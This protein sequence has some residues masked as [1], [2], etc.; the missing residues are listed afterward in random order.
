M[1]MDKQGQQRYSLG[2]GLHKLR[3]ANDDSRGKS[4]G[5]RVVLAVKKRKRLI[6]LH[7]FAKND[8]GNVTTAELKKLK[9][10]ADILLELSE[11]DVEKLVERGELLEV[12]NVYYSR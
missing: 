5:S 12:Q 10:L 2:A 1:S 11:S 4:G 3:L 9:S 7:L 6:W 8:K